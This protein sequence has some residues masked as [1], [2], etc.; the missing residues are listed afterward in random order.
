MNIIYHLLGLDFHL[1]DVT[2][3]TPEDVPANFG[4]TC[5]FQA[6]KWRFE[7]G[8]TWANQQ[9]RM[10]AQFMILRQHTHNDINTH[11]TTNIGGYNIVN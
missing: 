4:G 8:K 10:P 3:L 11:T 2:G 1:M 5:P 6:F 9:Q 7:H